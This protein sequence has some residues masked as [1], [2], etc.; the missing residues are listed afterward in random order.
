MSGS[1]AFIGLSSATGSLPEESLGG[2]PGRIRVLVA[3]D[4]LSCEGWIIL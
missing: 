4:L 1:A 3:L 2:L